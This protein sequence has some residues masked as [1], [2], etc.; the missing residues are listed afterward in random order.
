MLTRKILILFICSWLFPFFC[1]GQSNI[2]FLNQPDSSLI[3]WGNQ[4]QIEKVQLEIPYHKGIA[5]IDSNTAFLYGSFSGASATIQSVLLKTKDGGKTWEEVLEPLKGSQIVSLQL[6]D[7]KNGYLFAD[8]TTESSGNKLFVYKTIDSGDTWQFVTALE[9]PH[10][11]CTY[12][13]DILFIAGEAYLT[14]E[15]ICDSGTPED[16]VHF[17]ISKDNGSN[18]E[19]VN[20]VSLEE[21]SSWSDDFDLSEESVTYGFDN[22]IWELNL[23]MEDEI[24][25]N[26]ST[27]TNLEI[28]LE[29]ELPKFYNWSNGIL[30]PLAEE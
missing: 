16:G 4:W 24:L 15:F 9:K 18:W 13:F 19:K 14:V 30:T 22:S 11:E 6:E 7:T 23:E 21:Y 26:H 27:Q 28:I 8:W 17:F 12:A 2:T 25:V 10:Y 3:A 5:V 1:L 20:Q 29:Y